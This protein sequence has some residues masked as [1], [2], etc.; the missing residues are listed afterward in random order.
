[1]HQW[2]GNQ[3]VVGF[4]P[5]MLQGCC[6]WV[7]ALRTAVLIHG[8]FDFVLFVIPAVVT[9]EASAIIA[10]ILLD[11]SLLVG[12][13]VLFVKKWKQLL[14]SLSTSTAGTTQPQPTAPYE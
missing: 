12:S 2:Y 14:N 3:I 7:W 9:T 1:M 11:G 10:S 5:C 13:V 6:S 8:T 4:H